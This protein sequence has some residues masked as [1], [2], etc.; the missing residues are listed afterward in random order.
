MNTKSFL[1]LLLPD[2]GWIFTATPAPSKG[3]INVAHKSIDDAIAHINRLT[4]EGKAAYYA[5]ATFK[6]DKYWDAEFTN[7][8]GSKGKNRTRTQTNAMLMR[9][10]FLDLDIDAADP[11]KFPDK[12]TALAEFEQFRLK[13]NLPEPMVVD[14]GGGYHMYWPLHHA[15]PATQWRITADR[16]KEICIHEG[17][18][19][20]KSLTSDQARVLRALGGYNIRRDNPVRLIRPAPPIAFDDFRKR[21]D[22]YVDGNGIG[23]RKQRPAA[24]IAGVPADPFEQGNLGVTNDPLNFGRIAFHCGQLGE[25]SASRGANAGEQLWRATLGVVKFCEPQAPAYRAVSDGH[26]DYDEQRTLLKIE[27]WRTGPTACKHFHQ[28]NPLTCEAC[29]HWEKIT[30]PAQLGRLIAEAPPPKIEMIDIETGLTQTITLPDPPANY[31][32]RK[33]GAILMATED[34]DGNPMHE[35]ICSYDFYPTRILRQAGNDSSIAERSMWRAHLPRLPV[36]DMEIEQHMLSDSRKV[37]GY[38]MSKGVYTAPD[39]AKAMQLYMSA[40]LQKL[41]ADADREKLYERMGWHDDH[42]EFVLGNMVITGDGKMHPHQPSRGVRSVT[43]DGVQ[44]GGTLDGWT[45]AMQFYNKPGYEGSRFFLYAAFGAPLFHMNDTGN[46][47]VL[48]TASGSSGRGKTTTLKACSSV[49]GEPDALILNGNKDGS[50][51]NALYESIGTFHS[52]PFLWD[53][54]TERDP[55]EVRRVLLNISQGSGKVRMRDGQ[56]LNDRRISWETIVLASANTDDVSRILASG[57]DVA[58]HLMRLV[59]VEFSL[60][61]AGP[62][63]KIKADNFLRAIKGNYGHAGPLY[64]KQVVSNYKAVREG[65]IKNIAK[66]DRMLNSTNASAERFWSATVAA[67]YTGAKIAQAC[68]LLPG[69]PIDADLT[70]MVSHLASQRT[71]IAENSAS[72]LD[73]LSEF[74]EQHIGNM[75][76]L[77]AKQASNLDNV[78]VRPYN[79]LLI[80]HEVDSNTLYVSKSA[81]RSYCTE[82]KTAFRK[83]ETDLESLGVIVQRDAQKVLGADSPYA[84]GQTRSWK[85]D[86]LKVGPLAV[87]AQAMS[88]GGSNVVAITGGKA[89]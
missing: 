2:S 36:Q 35:V 32:R 25:M 6:D 51:V 34:R 12:P 31:K 23:L 24:D 9:S 74:L 19:A 54:I 65:Y 45:H 84:K 39:Q 7:P 4:F 10:F 22:D 53:D 29:P 61:D 13:L 87:M 78:V 1:Q 8:D 40:Y 88:Q 55:E 77:S 47:G 48:M 33:D 66:V 38:L 27:N 37:H 44:P 28:E 80:R 82:V 30:S 17:F 89:A 3:W 71:N 21:L 60:V 59:G 52:L 26:P 16:F 14:S 68:G 69:Y 73:V 20:D 62:E 18:R 46:K 79:A 83:L 43:K 49:W 75:L 42:R 67:A 15:V 85:I 58:P 5:M 63:A 64:M 41:A 76:V 50:T 56:G 11:R 57:K 70:W 72:P 86:M 81:I